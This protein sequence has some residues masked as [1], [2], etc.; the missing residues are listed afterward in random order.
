MGLKPWDLKK[1][2]ENAHRYTQV[3]FEVIVG[4]DLQKYI[5]NLCRIGFVALREEDHSK[6]GQRQRGNKTI[7]LYKSSLWN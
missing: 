2:L 5:F 1:S 3:H 7:M 4:I 6:D